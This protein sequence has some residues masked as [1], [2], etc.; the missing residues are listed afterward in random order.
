M[1]LRGFAATRVRTDVSWRRALEL[2]ADSREAT[3]GQSVR[4]Q[5]TNPVKLESTMG[6]RRDE[7]LRRPVEGRSRRRIHLGGGRPHYCPTAKNKTGTEG[8]RINITGGTPTTLYMGTRVSGQETIELMAQ[9]GTCRS[10]SRCSSRRSSPPA[11]TLDSL[12]WRRVRQ[13]FKIFVSA[14][15]CFDEQRFIHIRCLL[16]SIHCMFTPPVAHS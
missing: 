6:A 16:L 7:M 11:K 12:W 1:Y 13:Y 2:A 10:R 4:W 5:P 3:P 14:A 9:T 8:F 15:S